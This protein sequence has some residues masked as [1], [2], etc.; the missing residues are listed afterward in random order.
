M[1]CTMSNVDALVLALS[2][3]TCCVDSLSWSMLAQC[4]HIA[5]FTAHY[6]LSAQ[7]GSNFTFDSHFAPHLA[8]SKRACMTHFIPSMQH[9][10]GIILYTRTQQN[11]S[12][13]WGGKDAAWKGRVIGSDMQLILTPPAAWEH[14]LGWSTMM[15]CGV[16][17]VYVSNMWCRPRFN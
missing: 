3:C 14:S 11:E 10:E 12:K 8:F 15:S 1:A 9:G 7:I 17:V 16:D 6:C 4:P 5:L 2:S 13:W